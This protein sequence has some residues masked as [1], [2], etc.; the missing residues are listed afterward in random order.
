M[1][2]DILVITQR[3]FQ[4][5]GGVGIQAGESWQVSNNPEER[6]GVLTF[7]QQLYDRGQAAS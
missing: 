2:I 1:S 7:L 3:V 5:T 6:D 4:E